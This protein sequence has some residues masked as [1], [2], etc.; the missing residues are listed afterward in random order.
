[1]STSRE[2]NTIYICLI[3][4]SVFYDYTERSRGC[5]KMECQVERL[6]HFRCILLFEFSRGMKA[7]EA[8]RNICAC[9]GTMPSERM[10]R[11]WFSHFKVDRFDIS[12]TPLSGRPLDE[13]RINTLIHNDPRQCTRELANVMNC[14]NSTIVRHLHSMGKIK[15]SGV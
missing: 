5:K 2:Q 4:C 9:M 11:K 7:V 15:K 14:D 3:I 1:M 13:D 12:D 8:A 6:E 10:A